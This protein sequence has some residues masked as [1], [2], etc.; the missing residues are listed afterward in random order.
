[1]KKILTALSLSL[2]TW[3]AQ[4]QNTAQA[5]RF[6]QDT[7]K[8]VA[9]RGANAWQYRVAGEAYPMHTVSLMTSTP[10]HLWAIRYAMTDAGSQEE[11]FKVSFAMCLDNVDA[12]YRAAAQ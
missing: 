7:C 5:W 4:A 3:G 12:V 6:R 8:A 11:A 1:M 9:G 2:L 10:M